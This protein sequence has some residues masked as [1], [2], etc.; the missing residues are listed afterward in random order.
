[1]L[2]TDELADRVQELASRPGHEKVRVLLFSL[3]VDG[4]GVDSKD[5]DFETP[6]PEVR[7]RVDALLGRT[8]FELKSDLRQ[9]RRDAETGLTRYLTEREVKTGERYVAVAT[10]GA[11][12]ISY[13]LKESAVVE[14]AAYRTNV[15]TPRD[16][17]VHL[18]SVVT[19]GDDLSPDPD[20]I[21]REF[22]RSSLAAKRALDDL[23]DL[24]IRLGQNTGIRLK[25]EL[26]DTFLKLAYGN[27]VGD[28][29]LF[30]QHTYLVIVAKAV[31]WAAV[32]DTPPDDA[33]ALLH[34]TAF[35][36]LGITGQSD[37][38]FFDW[39]LADEAGSV[40]VMRI[41]QQVSRFH[42]RDIRVDILKALYESLI[43]PATRHDLGEYYTPDWLAVRMVRATVDDPLQQ[44]VIDPACGS[45]TFLFHAVRAV[46]DA[47]EYSNVPPAVAARH[48]A[49][50]IAGIDV[51]P[52]A[53]IF[54]RVT[55]LLALMPALRVERLGT[56][57][58][59]VYL[60]DALQWDVTQ[61]RETGEQSDLLASDQALEIHVPAI[62]LSEPTL[63]R[64]SAR[65]LQFPSDIVSDAGLFDRVLSTMIEFSSQFAS[66][67]SFVAWMDREISVSADDR[68]V[69]R[70]TYVMM[71]DLQKE[72]RNH[73]WGHV[74]RNLA[75]PVWL[76]S[77]AQKADVVIGNPPWVSFRFMSRRYQV[78][79]RQACVAARL[80]V[81][82]NVATHQDLSAYF[83]IRAASLYMRRTGRL[84]FVMPYAAMSRR[85]YAAFRRGE[86]VHSGH[87]ELRLQFTEAWTFGSD[88][89][90][91]FPVPSCALF[92]ELHNYTNTTRL[93]EYVTKFSGILPRRDANESEAIHSLSEV[94]ER[95]PVEATS[96]NG[97][98]YR[99]SFRQGATLSPRRL[100]LVNRVIGT[101]ML[102]PSLSFPRIRG[103]VGNWDKD[104]WRK[105]DP[106]QGTVETAFLRPTLLGESIVPFGVIEPCQAVI[107]WDDIQ[108]TLL[109]SEQA[110]ARGYPRLSQWLGRTESLWNQHGSSSLTLLG[111]YDYY[112]KLSCQF[113][114]ATL[115]VVYT[116]SGTIPAAAVVADQRAIIDCKL[117][118]SAVDS[119]DEANYLTAII[120]SDALRRRVAQY[121][122]QGQWGARDVDK[123]IFNIPFPKF[124]NDNDL[125]VQLADAGAT[126]SEVVSALS[127]EELY[128]VT[129][130]KRVRNTLARHSIGA[131][132][133][134][135]VDSL[136]DSQARR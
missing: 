110:A 79:F 68:R 23:T 34:G 8:V 33:A 103:R 107:P 4:L 92:A 113:P 75:R 70:K 11:N 24:W 7:G 66:A 109:D 44:R 122:A 40:L 43:D 57:T 51:H 131:K 81:G 72:G 108:G 45:G 29:V 89:Q 41:W 132:I 125:H 37:P 3:L 73:V 82:G 19:L 35:A 27:D 136:F 61:A 63:H 32:I 123:Y 85:A 105:L 21:Q 36:E 14:V 115:R 101:G 95:W 9:E 2:T 114:I 60:G 135:L 87:V 124:E 119:I 16:L 117:Y 17:L 106:P 94:D 88:L 25:R 121:Q 42:L 104:P 10:D 58:L 76:A 59:P 52:V 100:V 50:N 78:Q 96:E 22:G 1:M 46:L 134:C 67:E 118:W 128:F 102:P 15:E 39:V 86:L 120:N 64:L 130:R 20:T 6:L 30:L 31:A 13:F 116:K 127:L 47:A 48:A 112:G 99:D 65:T 28:D 69:L 18:Q 111:Q 62:T 49:E 26:W 129:A 126:A 90:P 93:P 97:S 55:F 91:L 54:S 74:A 80:W 77:A 56:V 53:V 84:A 38:D 98:P 12:F 5:I 83:C 133:E 71:H